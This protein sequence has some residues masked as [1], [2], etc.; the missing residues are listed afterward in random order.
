MII[1]GGTGSTVAFVVAGLGVGWIVGFP[2]LMQIFEQASRY[3]F[4]CQRLTVTPKLILQSLV[5]MSFCD[6]GSSCC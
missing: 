1:G 5:L 3:G 6:I 4:Q 2:M